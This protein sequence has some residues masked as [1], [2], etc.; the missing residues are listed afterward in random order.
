MGEKK[1]YYLICDTQVAKTEAGRSWLFRNGEW[2]AD[3]ENAVMDRLMGYDPSEP[4]DSPYATGNTSI[5]DE[6]EE[7]TEERAKELTGGRL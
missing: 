1:R 6:I 3:R 4:A 7:I 2:A 5:M